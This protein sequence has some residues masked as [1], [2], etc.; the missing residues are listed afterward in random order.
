MYGQL[1]LTFG[2]GDHASCQT[3]STGAVTGVALDPSGAVFSGVV[4][5]LL[6]DETG[7]AQ[8]SIYDENGFLWH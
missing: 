1:D 2:G 8:S 3:A 6:D 7:E 5:H 4:V